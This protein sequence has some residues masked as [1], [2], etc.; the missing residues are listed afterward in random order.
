MDQVAR[1]LDATALRAGRE[2]ERET[3]RAASQE[4]G[5]PA[6]LVRLRYPRLGADC[7][8]DLSET[9]LVQQTVAWYEDAEE[10]LGLCARCPPGGGSCHGSRTL[11][12]QGQL[13]KWQ[14]EAVKAESCALYR[15][16]RLRQRLAIS[17]IPERYRGC[18]LADFHTAPD[19]ETDPDKRHPWP[20]TTP[21]GAFEAYESLAVFAK[22]LLDGAE[23]WLVISGPQ[24]G[25]GKTHLVCAVLRGVPATLPRKHFW[26]ADMNELRIEMKGFNFNSGE[27]DPLERLRTTELLVVDNLE[28]SRLAKEAWLKERIEDVLYQRWNRRRATLITTHEPRESLLAAFP[29][30]TTLYEVP[31]CNLV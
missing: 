13:A 2:A 7:P 29:G 21:K 28:P 8:Q 23:P 30:I 16:W 3:L 18:K 27:D 31:S 19:T 17:N 11:F 6:A 26:Y 25:V 4:A 9:A 15:E 22:A 24:N 5:G 1:L 20:R 10:R 12:K 14:G